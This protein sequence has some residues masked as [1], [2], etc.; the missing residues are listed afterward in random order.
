[1]AYAASLSSKPKLRKSLTGL[2]IFLISFS[3]MV[4]SGWLFG[5][6]A[7]PVYAGPS[8]IFTWVIAGFFF[9]I[10]ALVFSELGAMFPYSG[11]LVRFNEYSHGP[12]SNFKLGWAY[13]VGAVAT[14]PVEAAA[15]T[16]FISS[17]VPSLYN[18]K[19]SILS[20]QGV[21]VAIGFLALFILIQYV[22]VNIFGK[23]NAILTWFKIG[24]IILT[25]IFAAA[26]IF[27]AKNFFALPGGFLPYHI[28]GIF[29]A[30]VP[31]GIIF[32]YEGFRQG[33]DYAGEAKNPQKSVPIGMI[34][35][36]IAAMAVYILLQIVFIGA[37][38]WR[39]AGVPVGNWV[40]LKSS[41]WSANPFYYAFHST[42]V[43]FLI[44]FSFLLVIGAVI[45]SAATLGVFTGT[46]ARSLYGMSKM[47]YF[48]ELFS[49]IHP[50]LQTP[51]VSIVLTFIMGALF[52]LPFPSWY[53][54]VGINATFTVYSYL[55]VGITNVVLRKTS[56]DLKRPYRTP[57]LSV[58][59][60]AGF[61]IASMLV[62]F[63]GWSVVSFLVLIVNGGLPLFVL[64]PYGRKVFGIKLNTA[65]IFSVVYWIL[66]IVL[67]VLF[68]YSLLSFPYYW[69]LFSVIIGISPYWLYRASKRTAKNVIRAYS[70]VIVYDILLGII[71]YYGSLGTN[72]ITFPLDYVIFA[73]A[74]GLIFFFATR[75]G[76]HTEK[77][78]AFK[79][80]VETLEE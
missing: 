16:S 38:N 62:Y 11:S 41:A 66:L 55:S 14:P 51:W 4:G 21:L 76:Y 58:L 79:A 60:P 34:S 63:S 61:I 74:S 56:P 72:V 44:G 20:T 45:S 67:G 77:I 28:S 49:R 39:A 73:V 9:I 8:I 75:I 33:L 18:P 3:G 68:I 29:I 5:V 78:Q 25:I 19:L 31:A 27:N 36:I 23:T 71:S 35:A 17:F 70:W 50:K 59:G 12:T 69:V 2:D 43:P 64:S 10:L 24:L 40:G 22:G 52:L 26:L 37:I 6:L 57:F 53:A 30:M 47:N 7:G 1:M 54:L 80:G 13:L 15:I 46:S 48:P 32:S 65:I 42:G